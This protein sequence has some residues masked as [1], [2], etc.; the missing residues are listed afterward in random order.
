MRAYMRLC[1]CLA[2]AHNIRALAS[3]ASK[4]ALTDR[5]RGEIIL[6]PLTRGGTAPFRKLCTEHGATATM[7]EM[8]F[9]KFLLKGDRREQARLRR[10]AGEGLFGCQ[11]ATNTIAEG[12]AACEIAAE[13]GADWMDLNCGCPIFEA[14][15]R[16]LGS[17]LLR[18]PHKLA[19]LA[20]GLVEG[21]RIPVS[22]KLRLSADGATSSNY[23]EHVQALRELGDAA[24]AF[25]TLHG[26]T[27]TARYKTPANWEMIEA[28]AAEGSKDSEFAPLPLVG[29]GDVLTFYEAEARLKL[30]PSAHGLMVGRGALIC[31]WIFDD[32]KRGTTWC[33]T[34]EERVAVYW[35]LACLFKE[36]FGDDAVGWRS[37]E[38]FL[39]W[40]FDFF[41]RWRPL[42]VEHFGDLALAGPLIQNSRDVDAVLLGIEGDLEPLDQLLRSE[43]PKGHA[44]I[45]A[46]LWLPPNVNDAV[47]ALRGLATIEN[48]LAW[49][50]RAADADDETEGH[51]AKPPRAPKAPRPIRD[52]PTRGDAIIIQ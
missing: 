26:R 29:N 1:A 17:V 13:A 27:A 25:V 10:F 7:G 18:K 45:A 37:V 3:K 23:I 12:I 49:K 15:R 50:T 48:L 19:T 24:P 4:A 30:A 16:G 38:Y 42:R 31:P 11:I 43:S 35:R 6:A 2:L 14:T 39:P 5:L 9:A 36:H 40:H 20:R 52:R 32:I 44:A 22:L 51:S 8:V 28:A 47:S 46:A 21:S 41:C 33:P 34:A